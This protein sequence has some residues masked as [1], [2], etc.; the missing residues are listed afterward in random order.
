[1]TT[2]KFIL[3]IDAKISSN[4]HHD[5]DSLISITNGAILSNS[6]TVITHNQYYEN[7]LKLHLSTVFIKGNV[8]ISNNFVRHVIKAFKDG[9]YIAVMNNTTV[10]ITNN[11]VHSVVRQ[12]QSFGI[13][14]MR[15]C[16]LQFYILTN[17]TLD[18]SLNDIGKMF[19]INIIDNTYM[20]LKVKKKILINC[21][22]IIGSAFHP[23]KSE[24]VYNKTLAIR[25]TVIHK[26]IQRPIPLSVCPCSNDVMNCSLSD[27]GEVSPGQTLHVN[28]MVSDQWL[29]KNNPATT[30]VVRNSAKDDCIIVDTSQLSQTHFNHSCN[31]YSYTIWPKDSAVKDC[32]LY[33]GLNGMPE[34]FFVSLVQK[35]LHCKKVDMLV[36]VTQY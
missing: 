17:D 32:K 1:M 18:N 24:A 27:L 23:A 30:L 13:Q 31:Q 5:G 26:N 34:M 15:I 7:I 20:I 8:E 35:G 9:S 12:D 28:F 22:W 19:K 36:I 14:S 10:A 2:N 16:R 3:I 33:I 29:N 6:S 11:T 4:F 25:N 21:Q